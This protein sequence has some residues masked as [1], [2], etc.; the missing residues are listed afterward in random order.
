MVS[1]YPN[2]KCPKYGKQMTPMP[3][4]KTFDGPVPGKFVCYECGYEESD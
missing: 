3:E 4:V 1:G 2:K